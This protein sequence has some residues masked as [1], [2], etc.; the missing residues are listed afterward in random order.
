MLRVVSDGMSFFY[1]PGEWRW[2][3]LDTV[4]V[5]TSAIE[6]MGEALNLSGMKMGRVLRSI[7]LCRMLRTLRILRSLRAIRTFRKMIFA[8]ATSMQTLFWAL[9]L[10]LF[11]MYTFAIWFT[12]GVSDCLHGRLDFCQ[13]EAGTEHVLLEY[14]G[15]LTKSIYTLFLSI[16][17]G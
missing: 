4:L 10:L 6:M 11:I 7:R 15:T 5:T 1:S 9:F 16:S 2:N 14:Y 12:S 8:L 17:T 3:M 13:V